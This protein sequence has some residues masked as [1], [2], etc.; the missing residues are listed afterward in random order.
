[1]RI[2]IS[3]LSLKDKVDKYKTY[4][5]SIIVCATLFFSFL[6]IADSKSVIMSNNL[7]DFSYFET[8]IRWLIYIASAGIFLILNFVNGNI[9]K[10]RIKSISVLNIMG[11]KRSTLAKILAM[12][13][14]PI[15][16]IGVLIGICVGQIT[17]QFINAFIANAILEKYSINLVFYASTLLRTIIYF[18]LIFLITNLF[19]AFKII[20]K[21]P[22]DLINDGKNINKKTVSK[23]KLI[24]SS[25]IFI[26]CLVYISYNIYTYFNL[27]RDFTGPIP[28]YE[29]NKVQTSLLIASILL[30]YSFFYTIIYFF[31]K[32]RKNES[33]Y[34]K[35]KLFVSSN[36]QMNIFENVRLLVTIV[37]FLVISIL[38]FSLPRIMSTIGEENYHNRMKNDIYVLT[39]FYV[40]DSQKDVIE[41]DYSFIENL[42]EEKGANLE[43]SVELKYF[44][45]RKED[46]KPYSK[47]N[48]RYDE[49]RLAISLSQYNELRKMQNLDEIEL[50]DNEFAYQLAN[51]EDIDQYK[52]NLIKNR[53]LKLDTV[54]LVGKGQGLDYVYTEN[55]G[56]YIY[57]GINKDLLIFPD[58]VTENL[59]LAK[60]NFVGNTDGGLDYKSA[61][62]LESEVEKTVNKQF[63]YL[64]DKYKEEL[65]KE[66]S[67]GFLQVIRLDEIEK[68]DTKFMSLLTLVLGTYIGFIFTI[69]VMTI[70]LIQSL[71]N[72]KN[73]L[74]N[75]K[76]LE[77]LGL[78][79]NRILSIN[80]KITRSFSL[81]PLVISI[82]II[83]S[84]LISIYIRFKNRIKLFIGLDN[85]IYSLL[86]SICLVLVF[87]VLYIFI[88]IRENKKLVN[89]KMR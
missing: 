17:S 79:K 52:D 56:T 15:Y 42:V 37:I 64:E 21:K 47:K 14:L 1:M 85:Y 26:I 75:Y 40:L 72:T 33:I 77:I 5:I 89:Q 30:M 53:K 66:N 28:N 74:E 62:E 41:N 22:I 86:I 44:Y 23:T 9:Y 3:N 35:D 18:S 81:I 61:K 68:V 50:K 63:S 78:D 82:F 58:K 4:F 16:C 67:E 76:M 2:R 39:D 57:G 29:S 73:S 59:D 11:A 54:E 8:I 83:V 38:A 6:S 7:Y 69:I 88:I 48:N 60:I 80:N 45:P 25:L 13:I 49:S 34:Q 20:K 32:K 55:L 10:I 43:G 31:D 27:D 71:I 24:I 84:I 87:I 12:E 70:L 46:F 51:T 65:E 36:I 19:N